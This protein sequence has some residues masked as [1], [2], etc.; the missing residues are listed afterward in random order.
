VRIV[1][2][3][4]TVIKTM[5]SKKTDYTLEEIDD[6]VATYQSGGPKKPA[7]LSLLIDIFTPYLLKYVKLTKGSKENAYDNRDAQEFLRLFVSTKDGSKK[8]FSEVKAN[9]A[10]TLF[11]YDHS[12]LFNEY[13]VIFI[14]LLDKYEKR[15]GI[16]FMRY[17]TRYFRWKLRNYLC[18][19]S[20]DPLFHIEELE[21]E[22]EA[23]ESDVAIEL[24]SQN[25]LF[26][27]QQSKSISD[28]LDDK[29]IHPDDISLCW[30][31]HCDKWIFKKLTPY[32][33]FLIYL[34]FTKG[35]GIT[36]IAKRLGRSKDTI[37][38]HMEKIFRKIK[39][40]EGR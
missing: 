21:Y 9:I 16:N 25:T 35:E 30:V 2:T 26:F 11:A 1:R 8:S 19:L 24:V 10:A 31:I 22:G 36:V 20:R 12:D 37:T 32:Q 3:G 14:V 34:Y 38:V 27:E 29:K 18:R 13:V 4:N 17:A 7:A 15:E 5:A 33:R 6:I 39:I 28:L 40:L 23:I